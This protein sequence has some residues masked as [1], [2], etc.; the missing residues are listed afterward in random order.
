LN[1]DGIILEEFLNL[2]L[3]LHQRDGTLAQIQTQIVQLAR[4]FMR[5]RLDLAHKSVAREQRIKKCIRHHGV[6]AG[7]QKLSTGLLVH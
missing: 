3:P 4:P 2:L 7:F 5:D 6:K 1:F